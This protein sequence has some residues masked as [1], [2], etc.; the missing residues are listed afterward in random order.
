MQLGARWY[1]V[2]ALAI[3]PTRTLSQ[4]DTPSRL[5]RARTTHACRHIRLHAYPHSQT[6]A[7]TTKPR[8]SHV[9][10][11]DIAVV[12]MDDG[13]AF[14]ARYVVVKERRNFRYFG[15]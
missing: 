5:T 2:R 10:D 4:L 7:Y 3:T 14:L 9:N 11:V 1:V 12:E 13:F 6:L 15:P 8:L